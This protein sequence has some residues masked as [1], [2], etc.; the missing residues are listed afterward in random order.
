MYKSCGTISI[1]FIATFD[2]E[3][4]HKKFPFTI[5]FMKMNIF[6]FLSV[7]E[8]AACSNFVF[9]LKIVSFLKLIWIPD[10]KNKSKI[11][12]NFF[13][14]TCSDIISVGMAKQYSNYL[15]SIT[16]YS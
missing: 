3:C 15:E 11:M 9:V 2:N 5:I 7:M 13:Y 8:N 1:N 14:K 16:Q 12:Y 6:D 4:L 10:S